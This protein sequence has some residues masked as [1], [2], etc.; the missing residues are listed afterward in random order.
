MG[1][2]VR[3]GTKFYLEFEFLFVWWVRWKTEKS[4]Q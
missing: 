2:S 4:K 1:T 3:Y